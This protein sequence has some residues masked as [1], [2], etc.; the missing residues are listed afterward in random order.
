MTWREHESFEPVLGGTVRRFLVRLHSPPI[1]PHGL[2]NTYTQRMLAVILALVVQTT[3]AQIVFP[4][5]RPIPKVGERWKTTAYDGISKLQTGWIEEVITA[6]EADQI[7]ADAK[8]DTGKTSQAKYDRD[9]NALVDLKGKTERQV[10]LVFPLEI[11]KTWDVKWNWINGRGQDGRMEMT[12]KVRGVER[13]TVS[14][15]SFD[16]VV[17]EGK[18]SWYNTTFGASGVVLETRWYAPQAKRSIRR[19]LVTSYATGQ[20]DVNSL[21]EVSEIEIKP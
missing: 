2:M 10:K 11:G 6:V 13:I 21:F 5:E 20:A 16:T 3:S 8:T 1:H 17:I 14:A 19:T 18:G 4:V 15:G 9:W 7:A 12:Y